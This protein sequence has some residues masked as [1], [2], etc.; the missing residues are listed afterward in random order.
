MIQSAPPLP[1]VDVGP[2][3]VGRR[4]GWALSCRECGPLAGEDGK[5]VALGKKA[6]AREAA[7]MHLRA[8]HDG[9]GEIRVRS[10]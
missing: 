2:A 10:A 3:K 4:T 8:K 7:E 1:R 9:R 6:Y 5:P